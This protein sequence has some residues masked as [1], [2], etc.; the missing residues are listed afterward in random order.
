MADPSS[1]VRDF[2]I[3]PAL[4]G[5]TAPQGFRSAALHCGIKAAASSLDLTVLAADGNASA[6]GLFTTNLAQAAP[7]ILSKRHLERSKGVARAIVVNSGCA[8]ACTGTQGMADADR[9][10][11]EVATGLGCRP[12]Q[13]LVASTG[14]IGVN[15]R[16]EK[17]VTGIQAALPALARGKGSD[18]ALAIMTT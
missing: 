5:V 14:V 16:M 8:N 17:V 2:T 4:G 3:A 15:L 12:E 9:M 7:V 1:I 6:A 18:T 11:E 10:A 13:V